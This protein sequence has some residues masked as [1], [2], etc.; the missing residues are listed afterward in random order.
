MQFGASFA[1]KFS[2]STL[3]QNIP[4]LTSVPGGESSR[5]ILEPI[6]IL[7][8]LNPECGKRIA[9]ISGVLQQI[10]SSISAT[11]RLAFTR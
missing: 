10:C 11:H 5:E 8:G 9:G 1:Q 4:Y 7:N 6:K 3:S 2:Q